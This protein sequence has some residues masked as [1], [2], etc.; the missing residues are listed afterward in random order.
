MIFNKLYCFD[1]VNPIV[2][3]TVDCGVTWQPASLLP[4]PISDVQY[5]S[6]IQNGY[7]IPNIDLRYSNFEIEANELISAKDFQFRFPSNYSLDLN[8][9]Y[10]MGSTDM[11]RYY[12]ETINSDWDSDSVTISNVSYTVYTY[13]K[14]E[15]AG[16]NYLLPKDFH[17]EIHLV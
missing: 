5:S 7:F 14:P 1:V 2:E 12:V 13:K 4:R 9:V 17:L 15:S 8:N 6:G 16:S 3:Y 11:E 10:I